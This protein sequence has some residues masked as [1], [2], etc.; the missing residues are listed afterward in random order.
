MKTST[1][2][3][4]KAVSAAASVRVPKPPNSPTIIITGNISS[5]LASQTAEPASRGEQGSRT[6]LHFSPMRTPT[7]AT[8]ATISNSGRSAPVNSRG[9]GVFEYTQYKIAGTLVGNRRPNDP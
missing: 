3:A 1:T 5:H 7:A 9:S 4:Q 8:Q 2:K 6:A